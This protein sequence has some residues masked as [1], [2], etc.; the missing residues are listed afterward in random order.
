[1]DK[2]GRPQCGLDEGDTMKRNEGT[3]DRVLRAVLAVAAVIGAAAVGFTTAGGIAL[4]VAA[5]ILGVTAVAGF[6]PLYAVFGLS[7]CPVRSSS[8][9][10]GSSTVDRVGT[11]S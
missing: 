5:A 2:D 9:A 10:G 8:S 7:T 1:V 4:L 11:A 6:C 3:L